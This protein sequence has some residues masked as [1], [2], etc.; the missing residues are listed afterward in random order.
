MWTKGDN[1]VAIK[2]FVNAIVVRR[3]MLTVLIFTVFMTC[4][5]VDSTAVA[6]TYEI[7]IITLKIIRY[8]SYMF[9]AVKILLDVLLS[10]KISVVMIAIGFLSVIVGVCSKS[11]TVIFA[12]LMLAA[13]STIDVRRLI[14]PVLLT[15]SI[16]FFVTVVLSLVGVVPDWTYI[17]DDFVRHCLGFTYPTDAFAVYLSVVLM[18]FAIKGVKVTYVQLG[19]VEIIN[20]ALYYLT[21]GRLSFVLVTAIVVLMLVYKLADNIERIG[22]VIEKVLSNIVVKCCIM[23]VPAVLFFLSVAFVFMYKSDN[24][25]ANFLNGLLSD[26]LLYGSNAFMSYPLTPFGTFVEWQGWGGIGYL[27]EYPTDFVYN[28]VDIS[29]IR[30]LF[31]YGIIGSVVILFG[32]SRALQRYVDKNDFVM[33]TILILVLLWC[34]VEPV[35]FSIGRNIFVIC[36][37]RYMD[38]C[39]ISIKPITFLGNKFEKLLA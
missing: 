10:R 35:V 14:K 17:R 24:G 33:A 37:A 39:K 36:L 34:F 27:Q 25:L 15:V 23:L 21:N 18:F 3:E 11:F 5:V 4:F 28:F 32:Y 9:F 29:Y 31:D 7:F 38:G 16:V 19:L 2:K 1:V 20:I 22:N 30:I 26:R 6:K 8:S 13:I 12:A